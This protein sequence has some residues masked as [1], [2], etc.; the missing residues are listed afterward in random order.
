M[1]TSDRTGYTPQFF[2]ETPIASSSSSRSNALVGRDPNYPSVDPL[3]HLPAFPNISRIQ[4]PQGLRKLP[5]PGYDMR[6]LR[7]QVDVLQE[8]LEDRIESQSDLYEQNEQLWAYM[9]TLMDANKINSERLRDHVGLLHRELYALHRERFRLAAKL[10]E[11]RDSA[12]ILEE[13]KSERFNIKEEASAVD[14]LRREA[15]YALERSRE[16]NKAIEDELETQLSQ[17]KTAHSMLDRLREQRQEDDVDEKADEF[18][19]T[20]RSILRG[21]YKRFR[22]QLIPVMR[23]KRVSTVM[24]HIFNRHI[25]ARAYNLWSNFMERRRFM[26]ASDVRR[27]HEMVPLC[28][29]QWKLYTAVGRYY[30]KVHEKAI[31]RVTLESWKE[32]IDRRRWDKECDKKLVFFNRR[33]CMRKAFHGWRRD[34]MFL[35]WNTDSTRLLEEDALTC[36]TSFIFR[37]WR[38]AT[39]HSMDEYE[40]IANDIQRFI[41]PRRPFV[42]WLKGCRYRWRRR[43]SMLRRF[44]AH[45]TERINNRTSLAV[46]LKSALNFWVSS[47]KNSYFKR[48]HKYNRQRRRMHGTFGG[49]TPTLLV[50]Q[51]LSQHRQRRLATVALNLLQTTTSTLRRI[52]VVTILAEKHYDN[53]SQYQALLFLKDYTT[54]RLEMRYKTSIKIVRKSFDTWKLYIPQVQRERVILRAIDSRTRSRRTC[55]KRSSLQGWRNVSKKLRIS[56]ICSHLLQNKIATNQ[57]NKF[58]SFWRQRWGY[59]SYMKMQRVSLEVQRGVALNELKEKQIEDLKNERDER[60]LKVEELTKKMDYLSAEITA[61]D[62]AILFSESRLKSATHEKNQLESRLDEARKLLDD[63]SRERSRMKA[64][65][66]EHNEY[67]R[68]ENEILQQRKDEAQALLNSMSSDTERLRLEAEEARQQARVATMMVSTELDREQQLLQE[69]LKEADQAESALAQ[70]RSEL[71]NEQSLVNN[72]EEQL[73]GLQARLS[74]VETTADALGF[75]RQTEMFHAR[76]RLVKARNE[77]E[78]TEVRAEEMRN[79]LTEKRGELG[80]MHISEVQAEEQREMIELAQ[81]KDAQLAKMDK[82]KSGAKV[83]ESSTTSL[84]EAPRGSFLSDFD[85]LVE[86]TSRRESLNDSLGLGSSRR[87]SFLND[88]RSEVDSKSRDDKGYDDYESKISSSA[89]F[90]P[91]FI[92]ETRAGAGVEGEGQDTRSILSRL[93]QRL[94]ASKRAMYSDSSNPNSPMHAPASASTI[95]VSSVLDNTSDIASLGLGRYD[96]TA[97]TSGSVSI[98]DD[99]LDFGRSS[100]GRQFRSDGSSDDNDYKDARRRVAALTKSFGGSRLD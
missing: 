19:W 21:A 9:D 68:K 28:L 34:T 76:Q 71:A 81:A 51:R 53:R 58:F 77:A 24:K 29:A 91:T 43:G 61:R 56:R 32:E 6:T 65:E 75:E 16:D 99:G 70:R 12:S 97:S 1:D 74:E 85:G 23:G 95:G 63:A 39:E 8:E 31:T 54:S 93:T 90:S 88:Y 82:A 72:A 42:A 18:W 67:R 94:S 47:K 66:D 38:V 30:R 49:K 64:I 62:E 13:L 96:L 40:M 50:T 14:R 44:F 11:A 27:A 87:H 22:K 20:S 48:W 37:R 10:R 33:K 3:F 35:E 15:E 41:T 79:L 17:M 98:G 83:N 52:R 7:K 73:S 57:L 89:T 45:L 4:A 86:G 5:P 25:K 36:Y 2:G 100:R 26:H 78:T 80:R 55:I 84:G 92:S 69:T 46:N 59:A 60:A